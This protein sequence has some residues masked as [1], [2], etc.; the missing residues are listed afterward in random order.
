MIIEALHEMAMRLMYLVLA[1]RHPR[2]RI[3]MH[4]VVEN[5]NGDTLWVHTH[6]LAKFDLREIEVVGV[7]DELRGYAH[8]ILFDIM[9]YM[10]FERRIEQDEHLGGM[11]VHDNQKAAHYATARL[12][13]REG[14]PAHSGTLRFVDYDQPAG[15]GFPYRLFAVH[16]GSLAEKKRSP[17]QREEMARLSLSIH[18]GSQDHWCSE[19]DPDQNP[20]NW[21]AYDVL[22]HAL[23][24]QGRHAEGI[25]AFRQVLERCPSAAI[26]FHSI[27]TDAISQGHLPPPEED[28]RS[29]FWS[30][31]DIQV[32]KSVVEARGGSNA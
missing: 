23:C 10:K 21:L 7:P 26:E 14:D 20:G 30:A 22:G 3:A 2:G 29:E 32:L 24:D 12:I 16:I 27:Y 13:K 9:G 31:V 5:D 17:K 18:S 25:E 11:F 1:P 15:S 6:G 8:G 4:A 28:P 19:T